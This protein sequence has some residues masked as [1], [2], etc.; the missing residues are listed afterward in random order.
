MKRAKSRRC[1]AC[2]FETSVYDGQTTT[3]VWASG[4]CELYTHTSETWNNLDEFMVWVLGLSAHTIVYFHNLKFDGS[5]IVS[6]L[7]KHGYK[8]FHGKPADIGNKEFMVSISKM[9]Q[10]YKINLPTK[11]GRGTIEIRDSL[12]L[13]PFSLNKI[14]RDFGVEHQKLEMD[15]VGERHAGYKMTP[16]EAA[17]FRN[18]LFG[19]A[20]AL[21]EV[22]SRGV[23]ALTIGSECMKEFKAGFDNLDYQCLFPD[24]TEYELPWGETVEHF[25]REAYRGGWCYVNPVYQMKRQGKG[26]TLD[27]NSLYPSRMHS[28]GGCYYPVGTPHYIS[29]DNPAWGTWYRGQSCLDDVYYYIRV[30]CAFEVKPGYLPT[31]QVHHDNRYNPREYLAT[32]RTGNSAWTRDDAGHKIPA[33]LVTLTLT[34]T[35]WALFRRHYNLTGLEIIGAVYF[36]AVT[37]LFDR[38][39]NK[40]KELKL[41][42]ENN[43]DRTLAKLYMNNLYGKTAANTDSSYKI[44]RLG[45]DGALKFDTVEENGKTPGYIAVGAA[46]TSYA[47][48]FTITAAQAN[49]DIFCYADTDSIHCIGKPEDAKGVTMH[50]K[51]FNCWKCEGIWRAGWFVRA[52]SYIEVYGE[53]DYLIKC[54]GMPQSCKDLLAKMFRRNDPRVVC[55]G[56][57]DFTAFRPGIEVHGKLTAKQ[58]PG[59]VLLVPTTFKFKDKKQIDKKRRNSYN[60]R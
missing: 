20:E 3:E 46:I 10:W 55:C 15:Y 27:V 35:D 26:F 42:A 32:S 50:D 2:D 11:R 47:R 57:E 56:Y 19:L 53:D 21:E 17:Y 58:I 39:L 7:L 44:P 25:C 60:N 38:Y 29:A 16:E 59:G 18:D 45:A 36:T 54:A 43:V 9:G 34:K 14:T 28:E 6:W 8:F 31:V 13:L 52:K 24:L 40:W 33:G 22:F 1:Y 12:K 51:N 37:G 5:F 48:E 23:D 4:Y 41:T 49:Y 30:K